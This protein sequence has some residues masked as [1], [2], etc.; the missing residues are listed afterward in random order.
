MRGNRAN[1]RCGWVNATFDDL[2]ERSLRESDPAKR[3]RLLSRAEVI[4][5]GED[6]PLLLLFHYR[7]ANV[8]RRGAFEGIY[9]TG[10]DLHPPR[11]IRRVH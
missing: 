8:I 3:L 5:A 6:S 1:N 4:L 7:S 2:L 10:R 9:P 11:Y